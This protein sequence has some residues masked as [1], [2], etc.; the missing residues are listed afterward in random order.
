MEL[1]PNQR[2]VHDDKEHTPPRISSANVSVGTPNEKRKTET[3]T[4]PQTM[5]IDESFP[6]ATGGEEEESSAEARLVRSLGLGTEASSSLLVYLTNLKSEITSLKSEI[7]SNKSEITSNK[8][9]IET[10]EGRLDHVTGAFEP[11]KEYSLF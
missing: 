8:S 9:R 6:T 4:Q 3:G 11:A 1:H 10:L 7:T 2:P 5:T